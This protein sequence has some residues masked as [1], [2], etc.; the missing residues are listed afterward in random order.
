MKKYLG[1]LV[2]LLLTVFILS[3]CGGGRDLSTPSS[4]LVGH[5]HSKGTVGEGDYYFGEIDKETGEGTFTSY[6]TKTGILV[7]GTYV[8][9]R[10]TPE[11]EA[12]TIDYTLF[13]VEDPPDEYSYLSEMDFEIAKDGLTGKQYYGGSTANPDTLEYI[14]DKTEY[15]PEE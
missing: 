3:A 2:V 7:K 1:F 15:E 9:A 6:G 5:W 13:G 14:D 12:I 4:R 8:V 10:E 11:G